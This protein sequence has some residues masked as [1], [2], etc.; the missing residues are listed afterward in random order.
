MTAPAIA[1]QQE[2][3]SRNGAKTRDNPGSAAAPK[4][5][6]GRLAPAQGFA[7][8]VDGHM[9]TT[10]EDEDVAKKAAADLL[11]KFPNLHVQIYNAAT[12][13]RMDV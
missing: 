1:R 4:H 5:P 10:Y 9:K 12:K 11:S 13:T 6:A 8:V 2:H 7:L 3:G